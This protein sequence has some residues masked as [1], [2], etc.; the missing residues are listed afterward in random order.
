[1]FSQNGFRHDSTQ[2]TGLD[3]P[4]NRRDEIMTVRLSIFENAAKSI[5]SEV[6]KQDWFSAI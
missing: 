1:M 6:L 4:E 5:C 2:T 3:Q